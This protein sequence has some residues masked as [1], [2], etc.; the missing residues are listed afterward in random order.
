MPVPDTTSAEALDH[1][2]AGRRTIATK[3]P[4]WEDIRLSVVALP[5]VSDIFTR[6]AVTEPFNLGFRRTACGRAAVFGNARKPSLGSG[7]LSGDHE[8][9]GRRSYFFSERT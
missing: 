3:G 6:P 8:P 9:L 7:W 4:A 5:P 2:A 1:Y